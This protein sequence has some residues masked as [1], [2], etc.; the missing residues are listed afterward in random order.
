MIMTALTI[1]CGQ[2]T[3]AVRALNTPLA[4]VPYPCLNLSRYSF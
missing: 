4:Y 1:Y 2:P 3:S